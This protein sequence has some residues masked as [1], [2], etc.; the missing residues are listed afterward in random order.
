M[1]ECI[2]YNLSEVQNSHWLQD[3]VQQIRSV[4]K[5]YSVQFMKN[6]DDDDK[7]DSKKFQSVARRLRD[8]KDP[9]KDECTV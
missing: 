7:S 6:A 2:K 8:R 5:V 4:F 9:S 1:I 3:L